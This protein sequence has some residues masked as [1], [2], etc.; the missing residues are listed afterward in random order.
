V[1]EHSD[2]DLH[3]R[4]LQVTTYVNP[5]VRTRWTVPW[6]HFVAVIA[7]LSAASQQTGWRIAH[8]AGC[9][10][11]PDLGVLIIGASGAGKS[12]LARRLGIEQLGDELLR[13]GLDQTG[14]WL[15][16]TVVPGELRA[17]HLD[18][19]PLRALLVPAQRPGPPQV[20]R[21]SAREAASAMLSATVRLEAQEIAADLA[22]VKD[23][24][25]Q[26]PT[27]RVSW[28]LRDESPRELLLATLK[29]S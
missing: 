18:P 16:G 2:W 4:L 10:L 22:W 28:D 19:R 26:V 9:H 15:Q 27:Y 24:V 13:L 7:A 11:R 6:T 3:R 17:E 8:A 29:S 20:E 5:R 21:L 25:D 1:L 14:A 12:T 23:L